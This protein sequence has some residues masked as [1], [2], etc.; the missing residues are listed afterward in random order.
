METLNLLLPKCNSGRKLRE[1]GKSRELLMGTV[2][3]ICFKTAAEIYKISY[4]TIPKQ[5]DY[6][7]VIKRL[8]GIAKKYNDC[9]NIINL[10]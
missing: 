9:A 4:K 6:E 10:E 8:G 2:V 3:R 1:V 5:M 7:W